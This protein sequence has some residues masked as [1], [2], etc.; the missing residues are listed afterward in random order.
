MVIDSRLAYLG[1]LALIVVERQVE[2]AIARRNTRRALAAGA[3]EAGADHYPWMVALHTAFLASCAAEVL[4]IGR[5]FRP[6]LAAA[7]LALLLL[8][9]ATRFWVIRTLGERW[10][11]RII[12]FPG[13]PVVRRGP[14]RFL[15]H[16]NYAAV[17]VEIFALPM[18]HGAWLT[19]GLFSLANLALLARRIRVEEEA[20]RLHSSFDEVPSGG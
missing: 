14:Y 20:L 15:R 17:V 13:R 9:A 5:P 3:V 19:A 8:A 2:L 1:L 16:P 4:V 6:L 18:V 11:T 12:C 7:M 10:T